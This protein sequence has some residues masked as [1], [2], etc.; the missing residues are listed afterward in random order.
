MA[1]TNVNK[2]ADGSL[3]FSTVL[4]T[5]EPK[6]WEAFNAI[7]VRV[8]ESPWEPYQYIGRDGPQSVAADFYTGKT[9]KRKLVK[10][11]DLGGIA[12][13]FIIWEYR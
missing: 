3:S 2:A 5:R 7:P 1:T 8:E 9:K 12:A 13:R 4:H 11:V 10:V 6:D